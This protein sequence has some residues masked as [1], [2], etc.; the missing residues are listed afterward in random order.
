MRQAGLRARQKHR[1]RPRTTQSNHN[2]AI[3]ENWLAKVPA[4]ACPNQVWVSDITCLPSKKAAC[5]WP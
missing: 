1:F 5:I 3:A 4:P 2:L